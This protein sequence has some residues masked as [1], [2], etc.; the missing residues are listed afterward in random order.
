LRG[1]EAR[2]EPV[3]ETLEKEVEEDAIGVEEM[4]DV[5]DERD[6][7][8]RGMGAAL[9]WSCRLETEAWGWGAFG[10]SFVS[11]RML[12]RNWFAEEDKGRGGEGERRDEVLFMYCKTLVRSLSSLSL[13]GGWEWPM[14]GAKSPWNDCDKRE[15][16]ESPPPSVF[17]FSMNLLLSPSNF[18]LSRQERELG[19]NPFDRRDTLGDSTT[20]SWGSEREFMYFSGD[21][22]S[23][24]IKG[25]VGEQTGNSGVKEMGAGGEEYIRVSGCNI[26]CDKEEYSSGGDSKKDDFGECGDG[27]RESRDDGEV[28]EEWEGGS[29][30]VDT[31]EI[32]F[33]GCVKLCSS[34]EFG[35][36]EVII[37]LLL[38]IISIGGSLRILQLSFSL[39]KSIA[40]FS[41]LVIVVEWPISSPSSKPSCAFAISLM[42]CAF[43]FRSLFFPSFMEGDSISFLEVDKWEVD[44]EREIQVEGEGM[45]GC[46]EKR[47]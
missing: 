20:I 32:I 47:H 39:D 11:W 29:V 14:E 41:E 35:G 23:W 19:P 16:E 18:E 33:W 40:I 13:P 24:E 5:E 27:E 3:T 4:D 44:D 45:D 31:F 22:A 43:G 1:I 8:G 10:L 7:D 6:G 21:G 26:E 42:R 15:E 9:N 25:S 30:G 17:P 36:E 34:W 28:A 12:G 38:R 46:L 37:V 2:F